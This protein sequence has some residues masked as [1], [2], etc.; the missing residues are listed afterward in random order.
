MPETEA[1]R[2]ARARQAAGEPEIE[3]ELGLPHAPMYMPVT[4]QE[5]SEDS[6][7]MDEPDGKKTEHV[8][9]HHHKHSLKG[10]RSNIALLT[11]LYVLQGIPL[12]LAGSI[13]Y[14]LQSRNISY[15]EQAVYSFV[16][17]PFSVKLLWAPLVDSLYIP[18]F[19]RRKTWLAPVQ[20]LLGIF[21]LILSSRVKDYL[22]EGESKEVQ[23]HL[24]TVLFFMLNFLAAT[25]D[26]VVDGWALTMLSRYD[27]FISFYEQNMK[28]N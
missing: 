17:W 8:E 20:Y 19:G 4:S 26:I 1:H 22:G 23:I 14:L 28:L 5:D 27:T 10:D 12:G 24:L 16:Y 6:N 25:Q 15:K 7:S 3:G 9:H 13:P 11:F 2:R 18:K 21:M